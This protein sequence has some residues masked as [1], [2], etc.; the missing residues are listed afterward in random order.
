[1]QGFYRESQGK[2]ESVAGYVARLEGKLSEIWVKDPNRIS[3][4]ETAEY[5]R[6]HFFYG[7]RKPLQGEMCAKFDNPMNNY[8]VL[9]QVARNANGEYEQEKLITPVLPSQV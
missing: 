5:I 7:L 6:D 4:V 8:M 2:S 9:V 1:M 3:E